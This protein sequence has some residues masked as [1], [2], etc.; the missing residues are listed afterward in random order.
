MQG[1]YAQE[2]QE[3][4]A[5]AVM[6]IEEL[7]ARYR[8]QANSPSP[9]GI[10]QQPD[11]PAITSHQASATGQQSKGRGSDLMPVTAA[12]SPQGK[13][14]VTP[15]PDA[16]SADQ[17]SPM[18]ITPQPTHALGPID[19]AVAGPVTPLENSSADVSAMAD[20]D[21]S[22]P[23]VT[24]PAAAASALGPDAEGLPVGEDEEATQV[25]RDKAPATGKGKARGHKSAEEAK[26]ELEQKAADERARIQ[27]VA[28]LASSVQPTGDTLA[29]GE[30]CGEVSSPALSASHWIHL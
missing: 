7:L 26:A 24:R 4:D 19:A 16:S 18:D 22:E 6:P 12:P 14:P 1:Q 17:T 5:E 11:K 21:G 3:L 28:D 20:P 13:G 27:D 23:G 10:K 8:A 2:L 29:T 30:L 9:S 25:A 15:L